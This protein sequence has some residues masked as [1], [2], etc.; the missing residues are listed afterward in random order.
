MAGYGKPASESLL[1]EPRLSLHVRFSPALKAL[2]VKQAE[3]KVAVKPHRTAAARR[4]AKAAPAPRPAE[5]SANAARLWRLGAIA[6]AALMAAAYSGYRLWSANLPAEVLLDQARQALAAR[7]YADAEDLCQRLINEHGAS[8][9]ALLAAGEAAAKQ[10]RTYEALG[11]YSQLPIDAGD[12]EAAAGYAAAG[13]ILLTM[14]RA[15]AAEAQYRQALDIDP[16]SIAAHRRLGQL[17]GLEGRRFESLPHLLAM[18]R[19]D[20]F[21]FEDLLL[22]GDHAI[23]VGYSEELE[24]FL[25]AAPDDPVPLLGKARMALLGNRTKDAQRWLKQVL[26]KAPNQ[27]EAQAELGQLLLVSGDPKL[28]RW[29]SEDAFHAEQHPEVWMTRGLW[30]RRRGE[31]RGAARCFWEALKRDPAHQA[32]TYQLAQ[33]LETLGRV[34]F[35]ER[36]GERA[37]R[38]EKLRGIVAKLASQKQPDPALLR[39]AAELTE[40]V[41]CAWEALAWR[42]LLLSRA[43]QSSANREAVGRLQAALRN[44]PLAL[45]LDHENPAKQIDLSEFALPNWDAAARG[46]K[47]PTAESSGSAPELAGRRARFANVAA[48]SGLDF[49]YFNGRTGEENRGRMYQ[50]TGGGAAVLDYDADGWPD[51]YLTQGCRWPPVS[52]Q[53]EFLD[54]LYRNRGDGT[55]E[56]VTASSLLVED[57]F[58]QGVAAGDFN[59][60]GFA[61]L[62]VANIG[63]NRLFLNQGDGTFRDVTQQ[64][65]IAGEAWTTSC[66]LADVN[67]DGLPD[68]YDVNYI[69]GPDVY[70][71]TCLEGGKPGACAPTIFEPQ[72]DRFY[73]NL[74]DGRFEEQTQAAGLNVAGG[75]GL[76]VVAG[77]FDGSGRLSLFVANDQDA[78]FLFLNET[79]KP[80]AAPRFVERGALAGLAFDANGKSQACMGVA[81]G[82][83]NAD[84]RLDLFVTN[85]YEESNTLYLQ[86]EGAMFSDATAASGLRAPSFYMLGFGAQFIDGELD[87]IPDLVVTNGHIDDFTH[88]QVPYQMP[89][90]YFR[91]LGGGRFEEQPAAELG[92]FFQGKYVGRGLARLDFNRDGREDF[93]VSHLDA[94]AALVANS[95]P[96]TGHFLAV[97]LRG[98]KSARDAIGAQATLVAGG[99]RR[100]QWLTAGDGYMASNERRLVFGLGGEARA[101]TLQIRWPSGLLQEFSEL[102]ADRTWIIVEGSPRARELSPAR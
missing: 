99:R 98:V 15:S 3:T 81:A 84:G 23:A 4:N 77:D 97:E 30:A 39:A 37:E 6:A 80:G 34:Q 13:D 47:S 69:Q 45:V 91:G 101:Q 1:D 89:A 90:Q 71:R 27:I 74:G 102:A 56:D 44:E 59:G 5:G 28:E 2:A 16:Q 78:N 43:P 57:R 88:R 53:T 87:G 83:A 68:I 21:S 86:D 79:P 19:A 11:Y 18:L 26:A 49:Q 7:K 9:P 65:G 51:I 62:Y 72:P 76:G 92:K 64:A 14:H 75:N 55:F 41:G 32:A 29:L 58:S 67:G 60:D 94:P 36:L 33:A 42:R 93:V 82:D 100:T 17:L 50:F 25:A 24:K 52:G 73:L 66:L 38:L 8:T 22:L 10:G 96:Q 40:S 31:L 63:V 20:Q 95:A 70:E 48:N 54:R 61:D 12:R 85:F 46:A 35:A